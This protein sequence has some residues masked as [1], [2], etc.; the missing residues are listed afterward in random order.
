[1]IRALDVTNVLS[2]LEHSERQTRQEVPGREQPGR[3]SQREPCVLLQEL[4]HLLQLRYTVRLEYLLLLHLLKISSIFRA[5]V[6][7]HQIDEGVEHPGPS[8]GLRLR[9]RDGGYR[10]TVPVR[11]C[12]FSDELSTGAVLLVRE[13]RMIH[14]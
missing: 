1:M 10:V 6:F 7:R 14:V 13:S 9:V 12:N 3:W 8:L 11:E 2:A 5:S 4:A